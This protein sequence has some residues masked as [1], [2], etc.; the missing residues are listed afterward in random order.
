MM[1]RARKQAEEE[2]LR[3]EEEGMIEDT[4]LPIDASPTSQSKDDLK[5]GKLNLKQDLLSKERQEKILLYQQRDEWIAEIRDYL[6]EGKLPDKESRARELTTTREKFYI[7]EE[8]DIL[9]RQHQPNPRSSPQE[10]YEQLVLPSQMVEEILH[11]R[12]D[13]I[14]V[15]AHREHKKVFLSL[16]PHVFFKDMF[17]RVRSYCCLLYT[18]PSPRD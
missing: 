15:G 10:I 13:T 18:S 11:A 5:E 7:N 9:Y 14:M 16:V 3:N 17:K 12:H 2:N 6:K 4:S 8:N 1:T